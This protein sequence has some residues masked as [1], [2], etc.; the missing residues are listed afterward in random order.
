MYLYIKKSPTRLFIC[1][2]RIA[3]ISPGSKIFTF[4]RSRTRYIA[5]PSSPRTIS[6]GPLMRRR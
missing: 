1:C 2:N 4:P 5:E 3:K 6:G